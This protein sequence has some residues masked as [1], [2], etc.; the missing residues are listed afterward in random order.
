MKDDVK[1]ALAMA[2]ESLN[3]AFEDINLEVPK[4]N[5][6]GDFSSNIAMQLASL[7]KK[8]PLVIASD[9]IANIDKTL[10]AKVEVAG[11]GFINFYLKDE[12]VFKVINEALAEKENFGRSNF[13]EGKSINIEFVSANPTGV[14]H[15]GHARG[16]SYGDSLARVLEFSGFKV[17]REYYINDAGNQIKNLELSIKARYDE[18]LG[19]DTE[20]PENGYHGKEIIKIAEK[21][22]EE[23][24]S[25]AEDEVFKTRGLEFLL[26]N[27]KKD[28][29]EFRVNFDIWSSEKAIYTSGKLAETIQKLKDS[30]YTYEKD[31]ALFLATS[32]F[33]D[34]K[35]RVIIKSDK[36][37]TYFLPDIAYHTVKFARGYDEL[38][39]VFGAD[40]HGY[41]PRL[42]AA[43]A[44]LGEDPNKL[45]VEIL[46]MVRLIRDHQEVKMSKRTGNAVSIKE[47]VDEVG[48]D[49]ARY[50]FA[51]RSID[52]AL[53]FDL[54]LALKKDSD[55]PV[56]Y[57]QYANARI[58][59]ILKEA[60]EDEEKIFEYKTL[61]SPYALALVK[62]IAGFKEIVIASA[63][64][65]SPHFITNYVY[66]LASLFHA[67]YNH[68]KVL[69]EDLMMR[70]ERLNL[71][72]ATSITLTN[73]LNLIGVV[74]PK[75]M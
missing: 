72:K 6:N 31:G 22:Y 65:K 43:M 48:V 1:K 50:F 54:D 47:L 56:Y 68:E 3:I 38:I 24:K 63:K 53:D 44:I 39:N 27:I 49:A 18:L 32:K 74:A 57:V 41:V 66:E 29:T 34:A 4:D 71:I 16:A 17:T 12:D 2:L 5:K 46:Q 62:K 75:E 26:D 23:Y 37:N 36:T 33:G 52:S 11:P 30:G 58:C 19:K 67:F 64:N 9:I 60:N 13:G 10:F 25:E 28:L 14:L 55:N 15:L 40:H 35:D 21:I 70:K 69:T 42:K 51:M 20:L 8:S 45:D 59:S 73:A 7:L 61:S